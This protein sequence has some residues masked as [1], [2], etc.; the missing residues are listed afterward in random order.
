MQDPPPPSPA[1]EETLTIRAFAGGAHVRRGGAAAV[2]DAAQI[3]AEDVVPDFVGDGVEVVVR[4]EVGHGAVVD[5]DME[6]AELVDGG[7]DEA[8]AVGVVA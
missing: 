6:G 2:E 8:L 1:T 3:C 4:D 5:E 7:L